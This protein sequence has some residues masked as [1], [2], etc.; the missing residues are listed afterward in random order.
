MTP[1]R[2]SA[3]CWDIKLMT[4]RDH[5]PQCRVLYILVYTYLVFTL[6]G[7]TVYKTRRS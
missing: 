1:F 2:V 3:A 7:L 6:L 4:S 5:T